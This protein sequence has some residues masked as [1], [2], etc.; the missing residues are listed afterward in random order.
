MQGSAVATASSMHTARQ[1]LC[2]FVLFFFTIKLLGDDCCPL[3]FYFF[4]WTISCFVFNCHDLIDFYSFLRNWSRLFPPLSSPF[5]SSNEL[6]PFFLSVLHC[7]NCCLNIWWW[8]FIFYSPRGGRQ[9]LEKYFLTRRGAIGMGTKWWT[10]LHYSIAR[11]G[12]GRYW[13]KTGKRVLCQECAPRSPNNHKRRRERPMN[14]W[15][16]IK[17]IAAW[18]KNR[19]EIYFQRQSK[20]WRRRKERKERGSVFF[21]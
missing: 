4:L 3:S 8:R 5:V 12:P 16:N 13:W 18:R 10:T 15:M 19:G 7:E 21:K 11:R 9:V 6:K 17:I 2:N 14:E 1:L 20:K